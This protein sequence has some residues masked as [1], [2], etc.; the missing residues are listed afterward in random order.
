L[1]PALGLVLVLV[2]LALLQPMTAPIATAQASITMV[3]TPGLARFLITLPP[4]CRLIVMANPPEN[5]QRTLDARSPGTVDRKAESGQR[6]R[7][8]G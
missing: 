6:V 5:Y 7:Y 3:R 4:D 1:P 2:V 8:A